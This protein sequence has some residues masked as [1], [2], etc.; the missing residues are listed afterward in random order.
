[1]NFKGEPL[2]IP[3]KPFANDK[4]GLEIIADN[5]E[6]IIRASSGNLV[7]S[8]DASWGKGKTTFI[9]MWEKKLRLSGKYKTLYFNAWERTIT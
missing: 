1:M 3:D 4:F 8:I 5:L 9:Q 6:K 7:L 2:D